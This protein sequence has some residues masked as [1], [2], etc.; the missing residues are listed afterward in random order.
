MRFHPR[1]SLRLVLPTLALSLAL[2]VVAWRSTNERLTL[3]PES[4]LWVD[5][6]SS[7][8]RFSCAAARSTP[9]STPRRTQSPRWCWG[10]RAVARCAHVRPEI[11]NAERG[12][13]LAHAK[14]S[15][16]RHKKI[17]FTSS[18]TM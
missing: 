10:E 15:A 3:Q 11:W 6:T 1:L 7:V 5:G 14:A 2:P 17:S 4:K 12:I 18:A 16:H 9:S 8:K 13:R